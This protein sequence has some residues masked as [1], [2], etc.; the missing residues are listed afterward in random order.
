MT[1]LAHDICLV[2]QCGDGCAGSDS[3]GLDLLSG[4][5]A[6]TQDPLGRRMV[7]AP[8][9]RPMASL[10]Q[11]QGFCTSGTG[12]STASGQATIDSVLIVD[13]S[14]VQR[15]VAASLCRELGMACVYEAGNGQ[16]ALAVL[17]GLALQPKLLIVDLEM[18]TMDGLE[19]LEHLRKRRVA[20][21]IIVA[22]S[23]ERALIN[24]VRGLGSALGLRILGTLQ[25]PLTLQKLTETLGSGIDEDAGAKSAKQIAL[26][27]PEALRAGMER[28]ELIVHYQPQ[29]ELATGYVRRV[30]ALVRWQHPSL[31]LVLPG[32]FIPVAEQHGLIH[33]LTLQVI[34]QALLQVSLW[35]AD[36]IDV[37]V[38]VNLSPLLLDRAELVEEISGLPQCHGI[39]PDHVMLE[40]TE[41][42][43]LRD[44]A[45]ALGVL[46]RFRLKGFGLSLDD[47]GTGF[48]SMQQLAR[49]PFTELKIDHSFVHGAHA[50]DSLKVLL[51]S[52]IDL[53]AELEIETVAEGVE[54]LEDWRLLQEHQCT[55]AQG[56]LLAKAMPGEHFE[57]WLK[58]HLARRPE[59]R[60]YAFPDDPRDTAPHPKLPPD[61]GLSMKAEEAKGDAGHDPYRTADVTPGRSEK[62]RRTLDDMRKLNDEIKLARTP[63]KSKE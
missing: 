59:L 26:V 52:A 33:Q 19:L 8:G 13:D 7:P 27:D 56:W 47:Y 44:F 10:N 43:L 57:G 62:R 54:S 25:K 51:R 4:L 36:G 18:P 49:I 41:S 53:A 16:E 12:M 14:A 17:D 1:H 31:G 42:S 55:L 48:S 39:A 37:S 29:V 6:V 21:P 63:R 23:R 50:R 35:K 45:V 9:V 60:E 2:C 3:S 20:L 61:G 28:G 38:A 24:S 15:S 30:E 5:A 46:T 22:S 11:Q 40:V 32:R 34:N 58:G